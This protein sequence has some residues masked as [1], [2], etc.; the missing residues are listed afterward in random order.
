MADVNANIGIDIDASR[1]LAQL[2]TL[3]KEIARF[4]ASVAR[5]SEAAALAQTN[6]Q[7]NFLNGVNAIQGFSAQLVNVKTSSEAFTDSLEN[8]KFSMREYFRY[9]AGATKTFGKFF[10]NEFDA[11]GRTAIENVKRLSTQYVMLGRD[12]NGAMKALAITPDKLDLTNL[13][14]QQQLVAQRQAIFNQLVQQGSTKLLN[15]GKNTQWAG[16]QLMVGFTIPLTILGNVAAK[17]FMEMETAAIKFKKVYGDLFTPAEE[18]S[19]ALKN[20]EDL[21]K[22]FT[23]YGIA[24]ADTISLAAEAAAAGFQGL[25]LQRQVTEATRLQVL[26]QI[27]QQKALETTISLQS[28]FKMESEELAGA[29]N[30][31]NAVENQTVVSLDDITTAIPKV[32]PIVKQLGGDITDLSYFMAAMKEGGVQAG[33]GANALKTGL[34]RL[35]SPTKKAKATLSN[36]GIDIDEIVNK[37]AGNL[38]ATLTELSV[39]LRGF[40]G[41]AKQRAI[42]ELFGIQ[43]Q[44]RLTALFTNLV[45]EG[46]QAS[47]VLDLATASAEDLAG[48]AEKELGMTAD[49]AMN[50][51]RSSVEQLKLAIVPLGQTFL[52]LITP[53]IEQGQKL[54]SWFNNLSDGTKKAMVKVLFYVG[55]LAPI[56]LMTIGLMA[57]FVAN[58]I[59]GLNLLRNGFLKLTGQPRVLGEQTQYLTKEQQEAAA[60]AG[61]LDFAHKDLTQT[62]NVER[63]ALR[64][65]IVEYQNMVKAQERAATV[66]PGMMVPGYVPGGKGKA[67]KPTK[68]A[69]GKEPV[70]VGGTGNKD[71]ELALLT[72]GETVIPAEMSKKYASII[73]AM[74]QDS[75]PKFAKGKG[76][77]PRDAKGRFTKAKPTLGQRASTLKTKIMSGKV[78][79]SASKLTGGALMGSFLPGQLGELSSKI[80]Q[81]SFALQAIQIVFKLFLKL[82]PQIR[83][84]T[85]GIAIL[86]GGIKLLNMA[87][88][89]ER[90]AVEGLAD[91]ATLTEKKL[92]TLGDFFGVVPT[93]SRF[94][95]NQT[96][97][98]TTPQERSRID[99]LKSSGGFKKEFKTTIEDLRKATSKE[100]E[101]IFKS[102]AIQLKG[103][104]FA[105][106]QI[107]TIINALREEGKKTDVVIDVK[108][109][110]LN[111][112][113]GIA[114][115]Q[116]TTDDIISQVSKSLKN[117]FEKQQILS[118]GVGP[119]GEKGSQWITRLVPTKELKKQ[120]KASGRELSNIIQGISDQFENGL[121][122]AEDYNKAMNSVRISL[123]KL[124]KLDPAMAMKTFREIV[125][126]LPE[127]VQKAFDYIA[128]LKDGMY[129]LNLQALGLGSNLAGVADALNILANPLSDVS[130]RIKAQLLIDE[131]DKKIADRKKLL[132]ELLSGDEVDGGLLDGDKK[133]SFFDKEL[134]MLNKKR[135]ALKE[136]NNELDRQ[137]QYTQKQMQLMS[138]ATQAKISGNYIQAAM[139]G[140]QSIAAAGSFARESQE[141]Q[142][143]K[144]IK[145]TQE[146]KSAADKR[147]SLTPS[148]KSFRSKL[149][150]GDYGSVAPLAKTPNTGLNYPTGGAVYNI[151]MNL[152]GIQNGKELF[153]EFK[154]ELQKESNKNNKSNKVAI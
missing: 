3:Q 4:H 123:E 2:K 81:L 135:D 143:S 8:N 120:I 66:F 26:G 83:L 62:F 84:I 82:S 139:I 15:F 109:L 23:R 47:R 80:F 130:D 116:K 36:M 133:I 33:E 111:T 79:G 7:R 128:N 122:S 27:D 40:D 76:L 71:T 127:P 60:A 142:V 88:E 58:G 42:K 49:S 91:A 106:D 65:L 57:N 144:L 19:A 101:L 137:Y 35:I 20:I 67:R 96:Q 85:T 119:N 154:K 149:R 132:D 78:S 59:K 147:K 6:L 12:A 54:L 46:S 87:K 68:R 148:D 64:R 102:L 93:K 121:I 110:T 10:Q 114:E 43:Q 153:G 90:R 115:L 56:L 138:D 104:G 32:G 112:K 39:A 151:N 16:R 77:Q 129:L 44:S 14:T 55:G 108:S 105:T 94:K 30:F 22:S 145:L 126:T 150:S 98:F 13:T 134:K 107:E 37:N 1:A 89:K 5:G 86:A 17:T 48:M 124:N 11:V 141:L 72:P 31:L 63:D 117:G 29:I 34:A 152:N 92:K 73:T 140:Q 53:V 50:K 131:T 18:T 25:D 41:L 103:S 97:L 70:T 45:S 113:E 100:A 28:A 136:V 52:E 21:G 24:V 118:G 38:K 95:T 146:R 61:S 125:K 51:F 9:S 75:I 74:I 99:D 69:K